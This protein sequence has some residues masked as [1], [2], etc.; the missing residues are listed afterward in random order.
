MQRLAIPAAFNPILASGLDIIFTVDE[1]SQAL[2]SFEAKNSL[3][4]RHQAKALELIETLSADMNC[5]SVAATAKAIIGANSVPAER[6]YLKS[7]FSLKLSGEPTQNVKIYFD[8]SDLESDEFWNLFRTATESLTLNLSSV[9]QDM[10]AEWRTSTIRPSLMGLQIGTKPRLKIY[11]DPS[12][13]RDASSNDLPRYRFLMQKLGMI[14]Q[15]AADHDWRDVAL[16][17]G[18]DNSTL[19]KL[20]YRNPDYDLDHAPMLDGSEISFNPHN[21][22]LTQASFDDRNKLLNTKGY[23]ILKRQ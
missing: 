19:M 16:D 22:Y 23:F 15:S 2:D 13:P 11:Y 17:L 12:D 4:L 9:Q 18:A 8:T 21:S 7:M 14:D 6:L 1:Q 10:V 3:H 20:Y 5:G